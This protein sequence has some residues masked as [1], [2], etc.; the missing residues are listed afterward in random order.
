MDRGLKVWLWNEGIEDLWKPL[1]LLGLDLT[2]TWEQVNAHPTLDT[3]DTWK[4]EF[5]AQTESVRVAEIRNQ[6]GY[7]CILA[8]NKVDQK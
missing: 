7:L 2:A 3:G 5:T 8:I 1:Y 4:V 6:K